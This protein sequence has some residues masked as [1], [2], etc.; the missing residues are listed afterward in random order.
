[1]ASG[2]NLRTDHKRLGPSKGGFAGLY[3]TLLEMAKAEMIGAHNILFQFSSA[4]DCN[5]S[6][7][8]DTGK[9]KS[10]WNGK[11]LA[12]ADT[13]GHVELSPDPSF[14][15]KDG[16]V[17]DLFF[18]PILTPFTGWLKDDFFNFSYT[19]SGAAP[20]AIINVIDILVKIGAG[21]GA[22]DRTFGFMIICPRREGI[23]TGALATTQ[24]ARAKEAIHGGVPSTPADVIQ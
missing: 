17:T 5:S 18:M 14:T 19:E 15:T 10:L 4:W 23:G 12:Q 3:P 22:P 1:M 24:H 13:I 16:T 11:T 21:T 6:D 7:G 2:P 8:T 20:N 9:G